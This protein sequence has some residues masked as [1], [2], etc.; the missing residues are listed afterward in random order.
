MKALL[1]SILGCTMCVA[2]CT[3]LVFGSADVRAG[4][5]VGT[6]DLPLSYVIGEIPSAFGPYVKSEATCV[7]GLEVIATLPMNENGPAW[8]RIAAYCAKNLELCEAS[9]F[10]E[11]P[12]FTEDIFDNQEWAAFSLWEVAPMSM[13]LYSASSLGRYGGEERSTILFT[14]TLPSAVARIQEW[15][16]T[17][18]KLIE[19]GSYE[20]VEALRP[21]VTYYHALTDDAAVGEALDSRLY[22]LYAYCDPTAFHDEDDCDQCCNDNG[23][24]CTGECSKTS[25]MIAGFACVAAGILCAPS[26]GVAAACCAAAAG[27]LGTYGKGKCDVRCAVQKKECHG[28]CSAAHNP[29]RPSF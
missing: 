2:V 13:V 11:L 14:S 27:I 12:I 15:R 6:S 20:Q 8:N 24:I 21:E 4:S 18:L 26:L 25:G 28:N 9:R 7:P 19:I 16:S 3:L 22:L 10:D 29:P 17:L 23:D 1:S 5:V